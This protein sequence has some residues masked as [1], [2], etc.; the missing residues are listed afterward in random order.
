[1]KNLSINAITLAIGLAFGIAA[2][3]D[4]MSKEQYDSLEKNLRAEYRADKIRCKSLYGNAYDVCVTEAKGKKN[5]AKAD[6]EASYRPS[7]KTQYNSRV[8]KSDADYDVA[9]EKCEALS[10]TSRGICRAD[11]KVRQNER[12]DDGR[13]AD[14]YRDPDVDRRDVEYSVAREKCDALEGTSKGMCR[15]DAKIRLNE[16]QDDAKLSLDTQ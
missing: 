3:A 2:M 12:E 13:M 10:G 5:V 11:A 7:A 16:R 1:M 15:A 9:R 6:L 8:I 14:A 4:G